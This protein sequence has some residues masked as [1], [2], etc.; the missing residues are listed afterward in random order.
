LHSSIRNSNEDQKPRAPK[1]V[2]FKFD[3]IIVLPAT[4]YDISQEPIAAMSHNEKQSV[5]LEEVADGTQKGIQKTETKSTQKA[6]ST[7]PLSEPSPLSGS[8]FG[9][10]ASESKS[11]SGP[12]GLLRNTNHQQSSQV[13][14]NGSLDGL[15]GRWSTIKEKEVG[16][17]GGG[18]GRSVQ[19]ESAEIIARAEYEE[20]DEDD[21]DDG[22]IF[23]LD[24][25][26]PDL[27][28]PEEPEGKKEKESEAVIAKRSEKTTSPV[29]MPLFDP[30][31]LRGYDLS[32]VV[33][34]TVRSAVDHYSPSLG[35]TRA[36]P[37]AIV[38][39][40]PADLVFGSNRP[41]NTLPSTWNTARGTSG[42]GK[43]SASSSRDFL[44][45]D[46]GD[47][48]SI[49]WSSMRR[50]SSTKYEMEGSSS[51]G[52]GLPTKSKRH[53]YRHGAASRERYDD[54]DEDVIVSPMAFSLPVQIPA[55]PLMGYTDNGDMDSNSY[56]PKAPASKAEK[57]S[58]TPK[59]AKNASDKKKGAATCPGSSSPGSTASETV[60]I[61]ANN[62]PTAT[63]IFSLSTT[64]NISSVDNPIT[65]QFATA[66]IGGL[67]R[68][69]FGTDSPISCSSS[70]TPN[71][72]MSNP[73]VGGSYAPPGATAMAEDMGD[74]G[75]Y[76]GSIDGC[77]GYDVADRSSYLKLRRGRNA[78]EPQS[79]S[80]RMLLEDEMKTKQ[81]K[82]RKAVRRATRP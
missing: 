80:E 16:G 1:Q 12:S 76:V 21:Y 37:A 32:L 39:S 58:V 35:R 60:A 15:G 57:Q 42:I 51:D 61:P 69:A 19:D 66:T 55:S 53:L 44:L 71:N 33:P 4:S 24:E 25:T 10:F 78:G 52:N 8:N 81:A 47:E 28:E 14:G 79:F 63:N 74:I 62:E 2:K 11:E 9:N 40:A 56:T 31:S 23:D 30:S 7:S 27:P 77:S 34:T 72:F 59:N 46:A 68:N 22:G 13:E 43:S 5:G 48:P 65:D 26:M 75:S 29:D 3:N 50:H 18:G 54:S 49:T 36:H 73:F 45:G 20:A 70:T 6:C 64:A 17:G 67:H 38:G 41:E 82:V